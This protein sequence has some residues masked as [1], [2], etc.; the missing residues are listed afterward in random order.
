MFGWV[1]NVPLY[2]YK[3]NSSIFLEFVDPQILLKRTDLSIYVRW[4]DVFETHI[5]ST[6]LF[7]LTKNVNP[8]VP[9][10]H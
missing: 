8:L 7:A 2:I 5:V 1:L 3:K 6:E 9:D 4:N 10:I